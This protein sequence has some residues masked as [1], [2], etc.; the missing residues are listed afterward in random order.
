M[1][2]DVLR[3]RRFTERFKWLQG[4]Q[5]V[6]SLFGMRWLPSRLNQ[7]VQAGEVGVILRVA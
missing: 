5:Q 6:L 2:Q 4:V 7:L 3:R 1:D